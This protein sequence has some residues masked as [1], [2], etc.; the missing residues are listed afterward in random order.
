MLHAFERATE[1]ISAVELHRPAG[2]DWNV[3]GLINIH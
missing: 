3:G 1:G 2:R